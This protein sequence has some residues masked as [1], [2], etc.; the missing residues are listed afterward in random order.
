M[1]T[2]ERFTL[3]VAV[4]AGAAAWVGFRA[5]PPMQVRVG[6]ELIGLWVPAHY[7]AAAFPAFAGLVAVLVRDARGRESPWLGRA[8]VAGTTSAIAVLRLLGTHP[9]SG[10]AVFLAAL[11][12]HE[13]RARPRS[14]VL[15]GAAALGLAVTAVYKVAWGDTFWGAVSIAAGSAIGAAAASVFSSAARAARPDP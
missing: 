9:L 15:L 3:L 2:S 8:A 4:S 11:A 6:S 5:L 14:P 7:Q 13:A 12:V 1:A 10:H